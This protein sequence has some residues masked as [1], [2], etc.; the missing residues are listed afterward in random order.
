MTS[1]SL[2]P[3]T[4]VQ[5]EKL[6]PDEKE[7]LLAAQSH[8]RVVATRFNL[9]WKSEM[10]FAAQSLLENDYLSEYA[11]GNPVSLTMAMMNVASIGITLNPARG[12]AFLVPRD[13]KVMLDVSYRGLIQLAVDDGAISWAAAE[14]VREKDLANFRWK[15][16]T[17]VPDH[18]FNP[19]DSDRGDIVGVYCIAEIP[20][21]QILS[22]AMSVDEVHRVRN[23]SRAWQQEKGPWVD[24]EDQMSKKVVLKR[25]ANTWPRPSARMAQTVQ[26][27]NQELGEG[28]ASLAPPDKDVI[29]LD[30]QVPEKVQQW[31]RRVVQRALETG[32]WN[33]A[34]D[35]LS[36]R[37]SDVWLL[38]ARAKLNEAQQSTALVEGDAA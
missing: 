12:Q 3:V 15:G 25:A 27:L 31:T 30:E 16:P 22:Q 17:A 29:P 11:K 24:F 1:Q 19:F 4:E 21:G 14:I 18:D 36:E 26:Y 33:T 32:A 37:L 20:G 5:L 23:L 35:L 34:D 2:T 38:W 13:G 7:A 10:L 28:L 6:S 9:D 8:F